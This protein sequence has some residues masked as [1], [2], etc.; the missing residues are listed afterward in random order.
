VEYQAGPA[1]TD[2]GTVR[3][4]RL[5]APYQADEQLLG[6]YVLRTDQGGQTAAQ[7]WDLYTVL[8]QAEAGFR[9][10]KGDLGLRPN[11]HQ[12]EARVDA[13]VF[14]SVLAYHLLCF[15]LHS[16]QAVGDHRC[17]QTLKRV[18]ETH[19]YTT[20]LLPTKDGKLY[21]IR[22]AGEPEEGQKAIYGPLKV[23][24]QHLPLSRV[25]VESHNATTL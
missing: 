16:L 11:F 18:L 20:I 25:L 14:I 6:C 8:T 17:W 19:A 9:A 23:D 13:H 3:W 5:E 7:A 15:I 24:W 2:P 1:P 10:I 12:K 21:R 22:R 4:T